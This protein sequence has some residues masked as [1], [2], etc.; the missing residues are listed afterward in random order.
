MMRL[1]VKS[2]TGPRLSM[3]LGR[4]IPEPVRMSTE[5]RRAILQQVRAQSAEHRRPYLVAVAKN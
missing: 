4:T 3:Q 5:M 2:V 1:T